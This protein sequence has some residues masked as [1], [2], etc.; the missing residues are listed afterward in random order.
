MAKGLLG[1]S[2]WNCG[3]SSCV[4]LDG[5]VL[6]LVLVASALPPLLQM[7]LYPTSA[8]KKRAAGEDEDRTECRDQKEGRDVGGGLEL[9]PNHQELEEEESGV[10]FAHDPS[11]PPGAAD[12]FHDLPPPWREWRACSS[13]PPD[14]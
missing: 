4:L 6:R 3:T 8:H 7:I 11:V 10:D 9:E 12:E 1:S 13:C 5:R 2:S 14:E